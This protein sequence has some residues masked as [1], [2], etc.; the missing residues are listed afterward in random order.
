MQDTPADLNLETHRQV[1]KLLGAARAAEML[2]LLRETLVRL[3]DMPE[4]ELS[5]TSGLTLVHRLKSEAGLMG[6]D[7]L[8]QACEAVDTAGARGPVPPD[9]LRNLRDAVA[10]A[11]VTADTLDKPGP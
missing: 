5:S 1:A 6:F 8:A 3:G 10:S 9:N 4:Q 7:R 11:L 2:A